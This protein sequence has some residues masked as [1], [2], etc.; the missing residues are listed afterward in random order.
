MKQKTED[1]IIQS[2]FYGYGANICF[3]CERCCGKC[4]WSEVDAETGRVKF[5]PVEGWVTQK[6]SRKV[7]RKWE[8]VEQIIECPL[9]VPSERKVKT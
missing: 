4:P 9:F 6:R 8:I 7:G 5:Q 2:N 3:D 1:K